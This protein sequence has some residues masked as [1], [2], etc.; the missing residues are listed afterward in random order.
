MLA[1]LRLATCVALLALSIPALAGGSADEAD[2]AFRLATEA[3]QE[4]RFSEA[5]V[6]YL[7]SNRLAPNR[8]VMFN[9][10]RTYEALEQYPEAYRWFQDARVGEERPDALAAIDESLRRIAPRVALVEITTD[11]PGATV[12]V[13]RED[14]GSVATT[15]TVL[16]YTPGKHRFLLR[17]DGHESVATDEFALTRGRTQELSFELVPIVGQVRIEGDPGTVVHLGSDSGPELCTTPCTTDLPP[18]QQLLYFVREGFRG[19]P[20]IVDVERDQQITISPELLP[21][22]GTLVVSADERDA[23]IEVDGRPMGFTPSVLTGVPVGERVVKVSLRGYESF[24]TTVTVSEEREVDLSGIVLVPASLVSAASRAEEAIVDAPSS[25][26][27]IT[28]AELRAFAYPTIYEA[29]RGVR[30]TALGF[31]STYSSVAVRG[32]GQANDFGNRLLILSDGAVLNDNILYQSFIGYDGRT[33]LGD[34]ER[35]EVVRGPGSVL[36]GTGAVSGVVN[37][38]TRSHD[39][40]TSGQVA[41]GGY[42][43]GVMRARGSVTVNGGDKGFWAS[44]AGARSDGRQE[45]LELRQGG[46]TVPTVVDGFDAFTAYTLAGNGW[47]GPVTAQW[48]Y[49]VRSQSIPT[50]AYGT[51][52][53]NPDTVWTDRR[54]LFELRYEPKLSDSFQLF[55][56]GFANMYD[57]DGTY[58]YDPSRDID[59]VVVNPEVYRGRWA[60]GEVRGVLDTDQVRWTTGAEVDG[61]FVLTLDGQTEFPGGNVDVYLDE[62]L[63]YSILAAY[64]VLDWR[65]TDWLRTSTGARVDYWSTFGA[66][67]NPRLAVIVKPT[68]RDVVKLMGGRAFRAPSAY[69]LTYN[70]GGFFQ[71]PPDDLGIE[72]RPESVL[73]AELEATHSFE[74]GVRALISGHFARADGIMTTVPAGEDFPDAI[75]YQN[76]EDPLFT[77]G[78][79]F[80]LARDYRGGWMFTG[81]YGFL[82]ADAIEEDGT[83]VRIPNAPYHF[84]SAKVIAPISEPYAR[85]AFRATLEAPRRIN[86]LSERETDTAVV[87]DLVLSGSP[88]NSGLTYSVGAY[89]VFDQAYAIPVTDTFASRTM[90]Q[91]GRS[92]LAN[93]GFEF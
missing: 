62:S 55:T 22:T 58:I 45:T 92:F 31:D 73:S 81:M 72:L 64:T 33:D 84:A 50:G 27:V 1:H 2:A 6:F 90:P 85:I 16:A 66:S 48:F 78:M 35:I 47:A 42:D 25:V 91:Q 46:E 65:P 87:A 40:P 56:R 39:R 52:F 34:V 63:P 4:G 43:N 93:V 9:I 54:G 76:G 10:G 77:R 69:E 30:G 83:N 17:L 89:N 28:G 29:L 60:G 32:L 21:I 23:V 26:S 79:D 41:V 20:R 59:A 5:L 88:P 18:G 44:L 37:L 15:P 75:V 3:Y 68:E 12:F 7:Q 53:G 8:S 11:P 38:V 36:Y 57:F 71:V 74:G 67:V 82:F 86:T 51:Q 19:V 61:S 70:D 49:T 24:E 13:D 14:L 80:E